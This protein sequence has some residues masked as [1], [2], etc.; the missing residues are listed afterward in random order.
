MWTCQHS[1]QTSAHES[2]LRLTIVWQ[3][4]ILVLFSTARDRNVCA[5][6]L[7]VFSIQCLRYI[8]RMLASF[9]PPFCNGSSRTIQSP[10]SFTLPHL[11]L[12]LPISSS[13]HHS[14]RWG[15]KTGGLRIYNDTEEMATKHFSVRQR[16]RERFCVCISTHKRGE[17]KEESHETQ[18]QWQS[19]SVKIRLLV[20]FCLAIAAK[21]LQ[22]HP[23]SLLF[24]PEHT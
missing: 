24:F 3:C 23:Y 12:S 19:K 14:A 10:L 13:C 17:M 15:R 18:Q 6:R 11:P 16:I 1:A 20:F 22:D 21:S 9:L 5:L 7:R 4:I 2:T 8:F